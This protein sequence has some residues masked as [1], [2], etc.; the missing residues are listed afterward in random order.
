M[1][2][3]DLQDKWAFQALHSDGRCYGLSAAAL[4][5]LYRS[6][7]WIFN[8]HGGTVPRPEHYQTGRLVY[9]GTDPVGR[10]IEIDQGAQDVIDLLAPHCIFFT[11]GEN[12]GRPDCLVPVSARFQFIPTRQPIVLDLWE[13][14]AATDSGFFTTIGNWRQA[15]S[16]IVFNGTLYTWSKHVEFAQFLDLPARCGPQFELALSGYTEDDRRMLQGHGWRVREAMS[17]STDLDAYSEYIRN[18]RGEFTSAKEQNVRLRSG[19]FSDRSASYLASARP[20][21]TQ[22][23]GFSNILP[24]GEGLFGVSTLDEAQ[25]AIDAINGDYEHHSR[26]AREVARECFDYRVVLPRMLDAL[27]VG[28]RRVAAR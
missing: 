9:V 17:F 16:D 13:P 25:Q 10:E 6:A 1:R 5:D 28:A 8:I 23:T 18:S 7:A 4:Q 14:A 24:T 26:A 27:G 22:E 12:H 21:V 19:W 11:W 15:N 20:V 3:Y 2:R